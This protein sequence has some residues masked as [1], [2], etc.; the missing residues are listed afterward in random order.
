MRFIAG[1]Q[2]WFQVNVRHYISGMKEKNHTVI[3]IDEEKKSDKVHHLF[4]IHNY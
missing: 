2:E 3:S 4:M 1:M